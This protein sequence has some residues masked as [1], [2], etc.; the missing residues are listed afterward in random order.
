MKLILSI[1]ISAGFMVVLGLSMIS[2]R[3]LNSSTVEN[4]TDPADLKGSQTDGVIHKG[5]IRGGILPVCSVISKVM[6]I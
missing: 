2:V 6:L 5:A 3:S 4:Y 1:A